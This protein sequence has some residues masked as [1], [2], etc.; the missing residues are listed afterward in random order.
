MLQKLVFIAKKLMFLAITVLCNLSLFLKL[1]ARPCLRCVERAKNCV[2]AD[3]KKR[4]RKKRS[5]MGS[6]MSN[7][8]SMSPSS[9][10]KSEGP[11]PSLASV[12]LMPSFQPVM[13]S[14]T[15]SLPLGENI[16]FGPQSTA[17]LPL[18]IFGEVFSFD[19]LD[20]K[21]IS[22]VDSAERSMGPTMV[23]SKDDF[24]AR[25]KDYLMRR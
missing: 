11:L 13:G 7:L 12:A 2:D 22:T 23:Y 25:T 5:M 3:A 1:V 4:G 6:P 8:S 10:V 17:D 9:F 14:P 24:F 15:F 20:E 16:D 21:Q 19:Q 18:D